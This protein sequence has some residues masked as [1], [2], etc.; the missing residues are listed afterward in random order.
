MTKSHVYLHMLDLQA[1]RHFLRSPDSFTRSKC[2]HSPFLC[3]LY[4]ALNARSWTKAIQVVSKVCARHKP[5]KNVQSGKWEVWTGR[6]VLANM[7]THPHRD[8]GDWLLGL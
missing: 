6:G 2:S 8:L 3:Y 7:P 1:Q 5:S 4:H